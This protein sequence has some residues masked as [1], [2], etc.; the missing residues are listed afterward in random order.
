MTARSCAVSR[1]R[2]RE[3]I[4]GFRPRSCVDLNVKLPERPKFSKWKSRGALSCAAGYRSAEDKSASQKKCV[5]LA[6]T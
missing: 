5:S 4:G 6:L 3:R 2:N 1:E